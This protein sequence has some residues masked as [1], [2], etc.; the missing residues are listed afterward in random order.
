M[1]CEQRRQGRQGDKAERCL[2]EH[3]PIRTIA[4]IAKINL[5]PNL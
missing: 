4:K 3:L 1:V 2:F 5:T